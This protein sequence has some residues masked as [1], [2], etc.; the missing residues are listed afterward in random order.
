MSTSSVPGNQKPS[1]LPPRATGE[2]VVQ[3]LQ[4]EARPERGTSDFVS[5]RSSS[6]SS[7]SLSP[8]PQRTMNTTHILEFA[9]FI[10]G[11]NT[12]AEGMQFNG[13]RDSV[14]LIG[15]GAALLD[16]LLLSTKWGQ[17][18]ARRNMAQQ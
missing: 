13:R 15:C 7:A 12:R 11:M 9:H 2:G 8:P 18:D 10:P 14:K 16:P 5:S 6:R 4:G 1:G 3:Q 17:M